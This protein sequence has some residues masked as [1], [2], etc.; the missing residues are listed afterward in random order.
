[1]REIGPAT[2]PRGDDGLAVDGSLNEDVA[3]VAVG[4]QVDRAGDLGDHRPRARFHVQHRLAGCFAECLIERREDG[5]VREAR[6]VPA[7]DHQRPGGQF[8][9]LGLRCGHGADGL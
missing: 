5:R 2:V 4:R 3:R 6:V 7:R 1:M 8:Q 9:L